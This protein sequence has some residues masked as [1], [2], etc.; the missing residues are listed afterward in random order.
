MSVVTARHPWVTEKIETPRG[1]V[2]KFV[3][4]LWLPLDSVA[5]K[6]AFATLIIR[7]LMVIIPFACKAKSTN[8][9]LLFGGRRGKRLLCG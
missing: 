8:I 6:A 9:I 7:S 1:H 5:A 4:L 3:H 2:Q